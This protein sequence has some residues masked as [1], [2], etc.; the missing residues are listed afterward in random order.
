[1]R[2]CTRGERHVPYPAERA[3][4]RPPARNRHALRGSERGCSQRPV[5]AAAD[6]GSAKFQLDADESTDE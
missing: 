5:P 3:R 2:L 4:V 1:M 6:L